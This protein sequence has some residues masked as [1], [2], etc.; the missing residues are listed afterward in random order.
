MVLTAGVCGPLWK[1]HIC[2]LITLVY[3]NSEMPPS[4]VEHIGPRKQTYHK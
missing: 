3:E 1:Y 2:Q 4:P